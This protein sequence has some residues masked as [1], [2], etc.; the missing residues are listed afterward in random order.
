MSLK[1]DQ[2]TAFPASIPPL[3]KVQR[4]MEFFGWDGDGAVGFDR[5]RDAAGNILAR[6]HD[7]TWHADVEEATRL[8]AK[9][10]AL[11]GH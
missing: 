5:K 4:W 1:P 8:A 7:A 9:E 11:N 2:A 6:H 3:R 10:E